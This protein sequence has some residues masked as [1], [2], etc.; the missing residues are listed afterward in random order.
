MLFGITTKQIVIYCDIVP[1]IKKYKN[2]EVLFVGEAS[3]QTH[4][5]WRDYLMHEAD[6]HG[7]VIFSL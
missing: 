5:Q 6:K 2:V 1:F 3:G 7:K 4:K